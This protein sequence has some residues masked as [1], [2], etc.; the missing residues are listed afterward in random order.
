[1]DEVRLMSAGGV[2]STVPRSAMNVDYRQCAEL[3]DAIALSA[4]LRPMSRTDA[5]AVGRQIDDYRRKRHETQPR[6]PSAGC[7]FKN[8][9]GASAGRLI[10]ESGLKGTRVGGA[11][12]SRVHANFVV[13]LGDATSADVLELVRRVRASVR[14]STGVDLEPEVLLYGKEW[15]DVL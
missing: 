3:R 15:R 9:P 12:V 4:V 5:G 2:V 13:N 8:P 6:E 14:E 10:E 11:E 7:I 1:V